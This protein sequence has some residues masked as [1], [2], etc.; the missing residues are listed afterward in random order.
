MILPAISPIS[1]FHRANNTGSL[2]TVAA[3]RAP[4]TGGF[5]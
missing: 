2:I 4:C 5:E 1:S 3:M